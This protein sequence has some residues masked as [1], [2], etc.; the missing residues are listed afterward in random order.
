MEN[1]NTKTIVT[2]NG[3]EITDIRKIKASKKEK[4]G[5]VARD[6]FPKEEVRISTS[7]PE[8]LK[9]TVYEAKK[10]HGFPVADKNSFLRVHQEKV[11]G[12]SLRRLY[13][14]QMEDYIFSK[15]DGTVIDYISHMTG[16]PEKEIIEKAKIH[17]E[18]VRIPN[19]IKSISG[20]L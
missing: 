14:K 1:T 5:K 9:D 15:Y 18:L 12:H 19:I 7:Y 11:V 20:G 16:I 3:E 4:N 2:S 8:V 6:S 17:E 13:K 10:V